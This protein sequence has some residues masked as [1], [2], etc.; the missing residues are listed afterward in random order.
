VGQ[1]GEALDGVVELHDLMIL[2]TSN[3]YVKAERGDPLPGGGK[4]LPYGS[5]VVSPSGA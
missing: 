1:G 5:L 4:P 3:H 2:E